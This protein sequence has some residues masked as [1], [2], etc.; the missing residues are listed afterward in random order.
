MRVKKIKIYRQGDLGY[1]PNQKNYS[2]EIP[3][4]LKKADTDVIIKGSGGHDHKVINC[5]IYF[6][7]SDQFMIGYL[8]AN[9]EAK[10]LHAEHGNIVKGRALKEANLPEM[11]YEIRRQ[12]EETHEGLRPVID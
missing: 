2:V 6:K 9:K 8:K 4:N 5:E 11:V 7:Q 10:L 12:V 3:K 1:I